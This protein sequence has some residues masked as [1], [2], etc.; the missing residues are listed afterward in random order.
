MKNKKV[1]LLFVLTIIFILSSCDTFNLNDLPNELT[2][3]FNIL[4]D[5]EGRYIGTVKISAT[6]INVINK[7]LNDLSEDEENYLD[8]AAEF[9]SDNLKKYNIETQYTEETETDEATFEISF[10]NSANS[11]ITYE[12]TIYD[13]DIKVTKYIDNVEQIQDDYAVFLES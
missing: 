10:T 4:G 7:D 1:L 2:G 11:S 3:S 8:W 5:T 9:D 12:F 13:N 6:S